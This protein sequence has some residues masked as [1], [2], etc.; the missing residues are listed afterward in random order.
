MTTPLHDACATT[1]VPEQHPVMYHDLGTYFE[2]L[3]RIDAANRVAANPVRS[4]MKK[5]S[6]GRLKALD[7]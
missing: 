2:M 3:E 1:G 4:L 6:S 5:R 7:A